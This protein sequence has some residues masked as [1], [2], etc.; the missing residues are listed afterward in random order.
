MASPALMQVALTDDG[1]SDCYYYT[2]YKLYALIAVPKK[3][4][5][6]LPATSAFWIQNNFSKIGA[7]AN[8]FRFEGLVLFS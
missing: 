8:L 3:H 5:S 6:I 4:R 1:I 2:I 7:K